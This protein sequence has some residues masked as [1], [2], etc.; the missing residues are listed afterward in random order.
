MT[1]ALAQG[2]HGVDEAAAML[3][4][5]G[6]TANRIQWMRVKSQ[7]MEANPR[8][9][10]LAE[11]E[12]RRDDVRAEHAAARAEHAAARARWA[13]AVEDDFAATGTDRQALRAW[14]AAQPWREHDAMAEEASTLAEARLEVLEP[15]IMQRYRELGELEALRGPQ[16]SLENM[17]SAIKS[18]TADIWWP[19]TST[20]LQMPVVDEALRVWNAA[21]PWAVDGGSL[22]AQ[23]MDA[24]EDALRELRPHA[25]GAYDDARS[26]GVP[27]VEAMRD[28][29]PEEMRAWEGRPLAPGSLGSGWT[30]DAGERLAAIAERIEPCVMPD[31]GAGEELCPCGCGRWPCPTT[32]AAW[33]ARGADPLQEAQRQIE[34]AAVV[35]LGVMTPEESASYMAAHPE[36]ARRVEAHGRQLAQERGLL[37]AGPSTRVG[38]AFPTAVGGATAGRVQASMTRPADDSAA[39]RRAR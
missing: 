37:E 27:A 36:F 33:L 31:I 34:A 11:L 6:E 14:T 13:P 7:Y 32:E 39:V 16:F 22:A 5:A 2:G 12:R 23:A 29:L 4:T 1:N 9:E 38:R 26:Y 30:R 20:A 24:A 18:V 21:R 19:E 8:V 10:D 35:P 28:A 3:L 17:R 15:L 25:M